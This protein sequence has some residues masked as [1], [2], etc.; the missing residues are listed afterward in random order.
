MVDDSELL[1]QL[2]KALRAGPV[3]PP[4]ARVHG[5]RRLV[6]R[7][8]PQ[9]RSIPGGP[10]STPPGVPLPEPAPRWAWADRRVTMAFSGVAAV[11]LLVIAGIAALQIVAGAPADH[12]IALLRAQDAAYRV[13]LA[14]DRKDA[15]QVAKADADLLRT[16]ETVSGKDREEAQRITAPVHVQAVAFL[17]D[18]ASPQV[19]SDVPGAVSSAGPP[20]PALSPDV[21][22]PTPTTLPSLT[23][24][25]GAP[26]SLGPAVVPPV[27]GPTTT[28]GALPVRPSVKIS[29]IDPRLDGDFDVNFTVAGFTPDA[30][31]APGTYTVRFSY[32]GGAD[33]TTYAGKSP[34]VLPLVKAIL[35]RQVCVEVRDATGA[36]VP[37]SGTCTNIINL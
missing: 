15:G 19:L 12:S 5:V 33:A 24:P 36:V 20:G 30:S 34:W 23:V 31:G 14:I 22:S 26:T 6:T 28:R 17:R 10:Q 7:P 27:D 16:A 21:S 8:R 9:L 32:D 18:H 35:H 4:A 13:Q 2:A 1:D 11:A 29:R 3:E 37:G 25:G